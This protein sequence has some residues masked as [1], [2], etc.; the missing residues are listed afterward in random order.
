MFGTPRNDFFQYIIYEKRTRKYV[1]FISLSAI[2]E[3]C[4]GHNAL[5][6]DF[7]NENP[8]RKLMQEA[9]KI[10]ARLGFEF[11]N[12]QGS[13]DKDQFESKLKFKPNILL[14]RKHLIY[15]E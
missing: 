3:S 7:N 9:I 11:I 14:E 15:E 4:A 12:L 13:E 2:S 5:I 1:G 10:A 6:Y 8:S